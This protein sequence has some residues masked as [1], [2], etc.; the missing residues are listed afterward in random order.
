M[1]TFQGIWPALITPFD[2][3]N[4]PNLT[5]AKDLVEHLIDKGVNGLL[6]VDL[7]QD[8]WTDLAVTYGGYGMDKTEL[9][10][11][12]QILINEEENLPLSN[13]KLIK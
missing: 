10:Q 2:K 12:F 6:A 7:D 11:S 3:N 1:T 8:G 4:T 5:I 9:K 13:L